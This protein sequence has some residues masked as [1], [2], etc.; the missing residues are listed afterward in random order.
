MFEL[1]S[2]R[3]KHNVNVSLATE[4]SDEVKE[5]AQAAS[6]QVYVASQGIKLIH[7]KHYGPELANLKQQRANQ[8]G[9]PKRSGQVF[10]RL[11]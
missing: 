4:L 1:E 2:S 5:N 7:Q 9:Q 3:R 11:Y 8:D 10:F 6:S